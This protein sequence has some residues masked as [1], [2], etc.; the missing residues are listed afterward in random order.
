MQKHTT[1]LDELDPIAAGI[2]YKTVEVYL[3]SDVDAYRQAVVE[4][5][6]AADARIAELEKALRF[7]ADKRRYLGPNQHP[8]P[9]DP[10]QPADMRSYMYDTCRDGGEVARKALGLSS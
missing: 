7:Y 6:K 9:D 8:I 1:W 2:E 10:Y 4:D 5:A 3:A